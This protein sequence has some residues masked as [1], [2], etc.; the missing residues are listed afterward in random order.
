MET[1][2]PYLTLLLLMAVSDSEGTESALVEFFF[3]F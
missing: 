2:L 1:W 3:F